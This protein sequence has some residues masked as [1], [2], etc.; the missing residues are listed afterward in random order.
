[1]NQKRERKTA[2]PRKSKGGRGGGARAWGSEPRLQKQRRRKKKKKRYY[3]KKPNK[4]K[5][6]VQ[7]GMTQGKKDRGKPKK[8]VVGQDSQGKKKKDGGTT[9]NPKKGKI[10]PSGGRNALKASYGRI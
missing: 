5:Q 4:T 8:V 9:K 3:G 1:M 10:R 2:L 6:N 7:K